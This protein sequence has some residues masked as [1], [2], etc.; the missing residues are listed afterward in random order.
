MSRVMQQYQPG[1][2]I[3]GTV[4]RV[5]RVIGAGGMG[6]VYEVEDTTVAKRYV[7]KTLHAA[8]ADRDDLAAR[9]LREARALARMH[10]PSIVEV[11][12]AGTTSD[13]LRLPYFVMER[14]NGQSLRQILV[15]K[16]RLEI[17][18][19]LDIGV[20]LL[21]ALDHAHQLGMIHRDV[22]PDNVYLHKGVDGT[23]V[24]KLLD[25]GIA[26]VIASQTQHTGGRFIGTFRYAS[27]E[28]ILG[29][30]VT[31]RSDLYAAGLTLYEMMAGRGPFDDFTGEI[32][33]GKAHASIEAPRLSRFALVSP[34]LDELIASAL[35]KN[36]AARPKD[37]YTF[38]SLLREL[39]HSMRSGSQEITTKPIAAPTAVV[40]QTHQ[41]ITPRMEGAPGD[42]PT[43]IASPQAHNAP[44]TPHTSSTNP[45]SPAVLDAPRSVP[46]G[47]GPTLRISNTIQDGAPAPMTVLPSSQR[48]PFQ[49]ETNA[50]PARHDTVKLAPS[51]PTVVPLHPEA[52]G[53]S[54]FAAH[55]TEAKNKPGSN[56]VLLF[57]V[58]AFGVVAI[59]GVV[60]IFAL[61]HP[62]QTAHTSAP[63]QSV[64]TAPLPSEI[65]A[66][67]PI[68]SITAAMTTAAVAVSTAPVLTT[69]P[70]VTTP[71]VTTAVTTQRAPAPSTSRVQTPKNPLHVGSGLD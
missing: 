19:A 62:K 63:P 49:A 15:K 26:K 55:T 46:H 57:A 29:K 33:I 44:T 68:P 9:L 65:T 56:R 45:Y 10:H 3:P 11:F 25:F 35:Q 31:P 50:E 43:H 53:V 67:P 28:Q 59:L 13:A 36:P 24:A 71:A 7:L 34:K 1:Q 21:D 54:T 66:P 22:K 64:E 20:D 52:G 40:A 70:A 41:P 32:E 2:I 16:T 60:L 17:D 39:K 61:R 18:Q 30:E 69:P 23:H 6:T 58:G 48:T 47:A 42:Q 51:P 37:A 8:L 38:A 12:T 14:L 27:P 5:H 4:Y